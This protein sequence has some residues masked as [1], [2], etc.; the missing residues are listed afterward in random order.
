LVDPQAIA[1]NNA[2]EVYIVD[3]ITRHVQVYNANGDFLRKFRYRSQDDV[4]LPSPVS[5]AFDRVGNLLLCDSDKRRV[6]VFRT[7]GTLITGFSTETLST[8]LK[9]CEACIPCYV[10]VDKTGRI[11]VWD[12]SGFV[13]QFAF[14][15]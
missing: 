7:D 13:Q 8:A 3:C 1:V 15:G 14:K 4:F 5:L 10:C 2:N 9:W 11:N 12:W 6:D